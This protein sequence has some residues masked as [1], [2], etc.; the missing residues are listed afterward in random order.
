MVRKAH[1]DRDSRELSLLFDV[2]RTL[3]RTVELREALDPLFTKL[4]LDLGMSRGTLTLLNREEQEVRIEAAHGLAG[5][6]PERTHYALGEGIT[7][8]VVSSGSGVIVPSI[9]KDPDFLH[10][11]W[12]RD[13]NGTDD[14]GFVCVPVRL[15]SETLGALRDPQRN[16]WSIGSWLAVSAQ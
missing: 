11:A 13:T 12:P 15:G 7:G 3:E 6:G 2:A 14:L 4:D 8:R 9:V 10:R 5:R 1:L 16:R